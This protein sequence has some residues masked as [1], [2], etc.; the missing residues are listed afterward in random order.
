MKLPKHNLSNGAA[1]TLTKILIAS[2][3]TGGSVMAQSID[4]TVTAS[5]GGV[6]TGG[7]ICLSY[8]LGEA[9]VDGG[10]SGSTRLTAGFQQPSSYDH[11]SAARS[12]TQGPLGDSDRDGV[13]NLLEY[14]FGTDPLSAAS[15]ARP[16]VSV[17]PGGKILITMPKGSTAGDLVWSAEVSTNL[18]TWSTQGVTVVL[19]DATTFSALYTGNAPAFLRL[20]IGLSGPK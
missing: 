2:C 13:V 14:A 15:Q 17:G 9:F 3:F 8:T 19:N 10:V 11:W 7:G 12:L 20:R 6:T 16:V 1:L 5:A 18:Q 4:S